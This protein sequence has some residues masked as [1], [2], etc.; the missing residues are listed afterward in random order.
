MTERRPTAP[1]TDRG[2]TELDGRSD[3]GAGRQRLGGTTGRLGATVNGRTVAG[4]TV[5]VDGSQPRAV[6]ERVPAGGRS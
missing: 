1:A 5:T 6:A 2:G 4:R 3:V